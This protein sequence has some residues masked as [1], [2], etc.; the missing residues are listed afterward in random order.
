MSKTKSVPMIGLDRTTR[1]NASGASLASLRFGVPLMIAFQ[2]AVSPADDSS[3]ASPSTY[4]ASDTLDTGEESNTDAQA[5]LNGLCW[6]PGSFKVSIAAPMGTDGDWLVQFPSPIDSGDE[7]NDRVAMEWYVAKNEDG[8]PKRAPAVVVVHES[9]SNMEVGRIIARDFPRHGL[10]GFLIYL[11]HYGTRR[12]PDGKPKGAA[13]VTGLRQAVADVRR[14]RDAVA[15]LPHV[16]SSRIFL[17]GTSLGGIVGATAAGLDH[18]YQGAFLMLAGGDL[19][20]IIMNGQRDAAKVRERLAEGGITGEKLRQLAMTIE[21]TRLAHRVDPNRVWLYTASKD[22]V[23]PPENS[24]KLIDTMRIP[25]DHHVELLADHYS[26]IVF[27]PF[28]IEHMVKAMDGIE[29]SK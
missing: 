22:T 4:D 26:G 18:G 15:A 2:C 28:I 20:G 17:Q 14:A 10:H 16:D 25:K 23:V 11:P 24:K 21:P 8:S 12:G 7:R 5:C 29:V 6:E 19:Y 13:I 1:I 9:G 27:L 3:I